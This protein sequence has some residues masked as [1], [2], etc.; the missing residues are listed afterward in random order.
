MCVLVCVRARAR[1]VPLR[2]RRK[3]K[4][5]LNASRELQNWGM[6]QSGAAEAASLLMPVRVTQPAAFTSLS[7]AI[8]GF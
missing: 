4:W 2:R 1:W 8:K 6:G 3:T 7:C 5:R